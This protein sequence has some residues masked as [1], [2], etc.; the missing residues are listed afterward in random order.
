[1]GILAEL[2]DNGVSGCRV[3]VCVPPAFSPQ[4]R[5]KK[6]NEIRTAPEQD[7]HL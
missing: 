6:A 3:V 7:V 4:K 5:R 1:M 2:A